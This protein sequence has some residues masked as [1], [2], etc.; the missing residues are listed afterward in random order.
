MSSRASS[1][2]RLRLVATSSPARFARAAGSAFFDFRMGP[3]YRGGILP[4][5]FPITWA[6][7]ASKRPPQEQVLQRLSLGLH[8]D[9]L[10]AGLQRER[11]HLG[12][13]RLALHG[14]DGDL[15]ALVEGEAAG[16]EALLQALGE[17]RE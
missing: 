14:H 12:D 8:L 7:I 16:R 9:D 10:G 6:S 1:A 11:E 4:Q 3:E 5:V 2:S 13:L 15:G 17:A